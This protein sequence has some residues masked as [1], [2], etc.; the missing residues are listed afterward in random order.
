MLSALIATP[1][2]GALLAGGMWGRLIDRFGR[3]TVMIIAAAGPVVLPAC[4][5]FA[6]PGAWWLLGVI[7]L[8]SGVGWTGIEQS[9]FNTLLH[10]TGGER[11][12]SSYQGVFALAMSIA[13]MLSGLLFSGVAWLMYRRPLADMAAWSGSH[14]HLLFVMATLVRAV[15]YVGLL[16]GVHDEGREPVRV[17]IR[18]MVTNV[19]NT[20]Y[21]RLSFPLRVLGINLRNGSYDPKADPD[22]DPSTA[23]GGNDDPP[24]DASA[25]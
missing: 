16:P 15:A 21:T 10:Y 1:N 7:P 6:G 8:L 20:I 18:Y 25:E 17:A 13:G 4:W 14:Y 11:G 22:D 2:L 3:K 9:N 19:Y 23:L 12:S 5:V 24:A